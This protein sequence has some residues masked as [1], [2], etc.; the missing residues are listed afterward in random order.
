MKAIKWKLIIITNLICLFPILVGIIL[1]NRLPETMAIHFNINYEPD[2]F[3]SKVFVVFIIPFF[4]ALLQTFCCIAND[5]TI[6]KYKCN[7]SIYLISKW[8][9]PFVSVILSIATFVFNMGHNINIHMV[10]SLLV[11]CI[12]VLSGLTLSNSNYINIHQ[13]EINL[14]KEK[15]V[16]KFLGI[17][18]V[19]IGAL[20]II[21]AFLPKKFSIVC[22]ILLIPYSVIGII[23]TLKNSR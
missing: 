9:L 16:N 5:I 20:F 13:K 18:S 7:K 8:I 15:K 1:W 17:E 11:G 22:L 23:Y 2:G 19:I 21:S 3:A 10:V 6:T 4:M 14:Q 12:L